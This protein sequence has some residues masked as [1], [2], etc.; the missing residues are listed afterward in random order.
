MAYGSFPNDLGYATFWLPEINFFPA[1]RTLS[2]QKLP[3][4]VNTLRNS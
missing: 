2:R 4:N 3:Q 1:L